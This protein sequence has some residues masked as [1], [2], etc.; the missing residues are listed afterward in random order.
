[1]EHL[2][3]LLEDE[4]IEWET[5]S[6]KPTKKI[7]LSSVTEQDRQELYSIYKKPRLDIWTQQFHLTMRPEADYKSMAEK[8][9]E[10]REQ[11]E[12]AKQDAILAA[13]TKKKSVTPPPPAPKNN[14]KKT[15]SLSSQA[16]S[17]K[18]KKNGKDS[19]ATDVASGEEDGEEEAVAAAAKKALTKKEVYEK[20]MK[21][22]G[23]L[24]KSLGVP[25]VSEANGVPKSITSNPWLSLPCTSTHVRESRFPYPVFPPSMRTEDRWGKH[26]LMPTASSPASIQFSLK[27]KEADLFID[28]DIFYVLE[29]MEKTPLIQPIVGME[30]I[31][32][33]AYRNDLT[34]K[35]E[36]ATK[37]P[38]YGHAIEFHYDDASPL[39]TNMQLNQ[40]YTIYRNEVANVPIY[41]HNVGSDYLLLSRGNQ[42]YIKPLDRVFLAGQ[43]EPTVQVYHPTEIYSTKFITFLENWIIYHLVHYFKEEE[44]LQDKDFQ[45]MFPYI[46][47]LRLDQTIKKVCTRTGKCWVWKTSGGARGSHASA[48]DTAASMASMIQPLD[49]ALFYAYLSGMYRLDRESLLRDIVREN[50]FHMLQVYRILY[51]SI[52]ARIRSE[53]CRLDFLGLAEDETYLAKVRAERRTYLYILRECESTPWFLSLCSH[54][55]FR[56]AHLPDSIFKK[57]TVMQVF[58][59]AD[60][61]GSGCMVSFLPTEKKTV[62]NKQITTSNTNNATAEHQEVELVDDFLQDAKSKTRQKQSPYSRTSNPCKISGGENDARILTMEALGN[63]LLDVG[64]PDAMLPTIERW[65]R[66]WLILYIATCHP[67]GAYL[68]DGMLAKYTRDTIQPGMNDDMKDRYG[69]KYSDPRTEVN[70]RRTLEREDYFIEFRKRATVVFQTLKE[71]A[72]LKIRPSITLPNLV[73]SCSNTS[74]IT[75]YSNAEEDELSEFA[76]SLAEMMFEEEKERVEKKRDNKEIQLEE[77][78]DDSDKKERKNAKVK[79]KKPTPDK[80]IL[81]AEMEKKKLE[82]WM[83]KLQEKEAKKEDVEKEKLETKQ[84]Q[85]Y[86][87][88]LPKGPK[89]RMV[90]RTIVEVITDMTQT[91]SSGNK[92]GVFTKKGNEERKVV[93]VEYDRSEEALQAYQAKYGSGVVV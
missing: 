35:N 53:K 8:A 13:T 48:N 2:V 27:R 76:N 70:N 60:P 77:K 22:Y 11:E 68:C 19:K 6:V 24:L 74:S 4:D 14:K 40:L 55:L 43:V 21:L 54:Y 64:V 18:G 79:V 84:L 65:D 38:P 51:Q 66:G 49:V 39:Y 50:V 46:P 86:I 80:E 20:R 33:Q 45:A 71:K 32:V 58:G 61:S 78:E 9:K 31:L 52:D 82:L 56:N 88:S 90:K 34:T 81:E 67:N 25:M 12:K 72:T 37:L 3:T 28:R 87:R 89:V 62:E 5:E 92:K 57:G 17:S 91:T 41:E 26:M 63:I 93:R 15:Q 59:C 30:G 83:S 36:H 75:T 16:A 44:K 47:T 7:K 42:V 10:R 23:P 69:S 85:D 1:M 29:Y 73:R